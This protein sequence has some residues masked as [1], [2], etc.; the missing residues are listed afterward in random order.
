LKHYLPKPYS[1][2][3]KLTKNYRHQISEDA[4]DMSAY[5]S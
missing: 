1:G 3:V 4:G 5:P 2:L